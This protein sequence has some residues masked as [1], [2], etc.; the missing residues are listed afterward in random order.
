MLRAVF[1]AGCY[2][3]FR[4]N[5]INEILMILLTAVTIL[6]FLVA[7]KIWRELR[8]DKYVHRE[9]ARIRDD[10]LRERLLMLPA[11]DFHGLCLRIME[12]LPGFEG[13]Y[14]VTFQRVSP[15][16]EDDILTAFH[17]AQK[18]GY[19]EMALFSLSRL[20]EAAQSAP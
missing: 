11:A 10:V 8:F 16:S 5:I 7:L 15:L 1:A 13:A 20:S 17:A 6:L 12:R 18:E 2:L 9:E 19:S 3:W 14:L 4:Q